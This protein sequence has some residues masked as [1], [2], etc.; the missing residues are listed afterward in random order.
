MAKRIADWRLPYDAKYITGHYGTMS[1]F[2]K[3]NN[4]QPHSGTDWAR[5]RGTRIPAIAKGTIQLIQFSKVLGWVVVQTAMDKDGVIW[6]LGYCHMDSRPG[7]QVG[8]KL[9]KGQTVGTIGSTG[10]GSGPH[11]H[12]TAS[13]TLKGVFGVTSAKADLYKLILANTKRAAARQ[14]AEPPNQTKSVE[15]CKCCK[16]PL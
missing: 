7:Y 3:A 8:Q 16:R 10:A 2:R 13:K 11:L 6:Y 4:M 12:A 15:V 14:V 9:A 1:E 5:P